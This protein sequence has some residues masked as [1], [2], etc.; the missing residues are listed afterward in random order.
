MNKEQF[1]KRLDSLLQELPEHEREDILDDYEEHFLSGEQDGK[2]EEEIVNELGD[3]KTIAKEITAHHYVEAASENRSMKNMWKAI[4]ATVSLSFFNLIFILGPAFGLLGVYIG[5]W[6]VAVSLLL[7]PLVLISTW[8]F[9]AS[10]ASFFLS[11]SMS[12]TSLG[13]GLLL[14]IGLIYTGKWLYK[15]TVSYMKY[16]IGIVKGGEK[17]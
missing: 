5:I 8:I 11:I 4:L 14:S 17:G 10:D 16:N 13:L 3:P 6:G 7:I 9:G 2:G 1:M 12:L 15:G